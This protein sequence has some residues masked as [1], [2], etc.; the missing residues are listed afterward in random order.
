MQASTLHLYWFALR[1]G[2]ARIFLHSYGTMTMSPPSHS[3]CHALHWFINL[4]IYPKA[5]FDS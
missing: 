2:H 4:N 3:Y 5:S 1:T